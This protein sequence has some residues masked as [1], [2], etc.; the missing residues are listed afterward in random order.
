[1]ALIPLRRGQLTHCFKIPLALMIARLE[2][3]SNEYLSPNSPTGGFN[4]LFN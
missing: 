3:L 1:M 4:L 2:M